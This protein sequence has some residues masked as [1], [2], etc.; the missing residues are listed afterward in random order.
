MNQSDRTLRSSLSS[1]K[2]S[3]LTC[4]LPKCVAVQRG[5][6]SSTSKVDLLLVP[7]LRGRVSPDISA[8]ELLISHLRELLSTRTTLRPG[9]YWVS[10]GKS[11]ALNG[12]ESTE[13][14]VTLSFQ[15]EHPKKKE[16]A[17]GRALLKLR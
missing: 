13:I 11:W 2:N 8:E 3:T 14:S 6:G 12:E 4:A 17:Q 16:S 10:L 5:N 1:P 7:S 9:S 15:V